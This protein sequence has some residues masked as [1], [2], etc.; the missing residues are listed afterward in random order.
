MGSG[1]GIGVPCPNKGL[2]L[3]AT[4]PGFKSK[5]CLLLLGPQAG[6]QAGKG[7]NFLTVASFF[8]SLQGII[9]GKLEM[10]WMS[11]PF[12]PHIGM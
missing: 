12:L 11:L 1:D 9:K 7:L 10:P 8:Y 6:P 5:G 4:G 3:G 2:E